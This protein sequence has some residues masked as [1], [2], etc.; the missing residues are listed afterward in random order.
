MS[1]T[2]YAWSFIYW[3]FFKAFYS[4]YSSIDTVDNLCSSCQCFIV[5]SVFSSTIKIKFSNIIFF[6]IF[7]LYYTCKGLYGRVS[8]LIQWLLF[9]TSI[10]RTYFT[11]IQKQF[12]V[13]DVWQVNVHN[14]HITKLVF[15]F[16][17]NLTLT[18]MI[19]WNSQT[20]IMQ[21]P[22]NYFIGIINILKWWSVLSLWNLIYSFP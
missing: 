8:W 12:F 11:R 10:K 3:Y 13:K 14:S 19:N 7:F 20:I 2:D 16:Y 22:I 5:Q 6:L 4:Y 9:F 17:K 18:S 15:L 21:L 1:V